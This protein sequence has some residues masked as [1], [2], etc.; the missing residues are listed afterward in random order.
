M[1]MIIYMIMCWMSSAGAVII[2]FILRGKDC[3]TISGVVFLPV[4]DLIIG[5]FNIYFLCKWWRQK[6][7]N[8]I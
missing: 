4:L 7:G 1:C 5:D 8:D 2:V 3:T 6:C